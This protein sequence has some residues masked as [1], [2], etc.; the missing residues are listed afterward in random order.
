MLCTG[1]ASASVAEALFNVAVMLA[2]GEAE[3]M[4]MMRS[5]CVCVALV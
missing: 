5:S 3:G 1:D 2:E 4:T